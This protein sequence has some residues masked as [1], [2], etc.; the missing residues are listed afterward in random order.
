MIPATL[1]NRTQSAA[2]AA[3]QTWGQ[4]PQ[5]RQCQEE[6]NELAAAINRMLRGRPDG[7]TQ[8]VEETA[9]VFVCLVQL[10]LMLGAEVDAVIERKLA[11]LEARI[12]AARTER[13]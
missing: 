11:R 2:L 9:D 4:E 1:L 5:L 6:L 12:A 7:W 3:I 10:R 13:A 8:V